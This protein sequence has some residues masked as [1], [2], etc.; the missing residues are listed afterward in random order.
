MKG[1]PPSGRGPRFTAQAKQTRAC[2][3]S[4]SYDQWAGR[5]TP[6]S[7]S[8]AVRGLYKK[9]QP[10]TFSLSAAEASHSLPSRLP[11]KAEAGDLLDQLYNGL[12]MRRLATEPLHET[13]VEDSALSFRS[14]S[15]TADDESLY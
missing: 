13:K 1:D 10:M 6:V 14:M 12:P 5:G 11:E 3:M 8:S 7:S 9:R 15:K 4:L 2:C